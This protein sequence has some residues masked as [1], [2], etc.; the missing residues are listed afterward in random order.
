MNNMRDTVADPS[1]MQASSGIGLKKQ[2][3]DFDH[4]RKST[5]FESDRSKL[6]NYNGFGTS[7]QNLGRE[8]ISEAD[9][10]KEYTVQEKSATNDNA[11][12]F[13]RQSN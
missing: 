3:N 9:A 1:M 8:I 5:G 7:L 13:G 11:F 2:S 12:S 10:D 4:G 6:S